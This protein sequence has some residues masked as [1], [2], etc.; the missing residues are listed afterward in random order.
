MRTKR[1]EHGRIIMDESHTIEVS[2]MFAIDP[3]HEVTIT[4]RPF[5]GNEGQ[6]GYQFT[7]Q[8]GRVEYIY[9]NTSNGGDGEQG[10]GGGPG[11][12]TFVYKG[13]EGHPAEDTPQVFHYLFDPEDWD[14]PTGGDS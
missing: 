1:V 10:P 6:V 12:N 14:E 13:T 8:D 9:F 3:D 7:H 2:E 11:F 5:I 4:Q